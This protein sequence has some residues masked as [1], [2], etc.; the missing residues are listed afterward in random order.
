MRSLRYAKLP[1]AVL[2]TSMLLAACSG[3]SGNNS[4]GGEDYIFTSYIGQP[5]NALIPG[6]TTESEGAEVLSAL[7]TG[8][9]TYAVKD[10][11][12]EYN[13]VAE[14]IESEDLQN[15][16]I[17]LNEGWTFHDGTPV[18]SDS[19]I[20]AWNYTAK[21]ENAF[22]GASF[23]SN[24]QGYEQVAGK[25]DDDGNITEQASADALS[26]LKK[27]DDLTFQV[28]LNAPFAAYPT[29]VGYNAYL[30]LPES[31]F[32]DPAAYEKKP[33]GNGPYKIDGEWSKD[34]GGK[35]VKYA[36][37]KGP[38]K[39]QNAGVQFKIYQ[40]INTGY[41]D[42]QAGNIDV[43][44][45]LPVD[46]VGTAKQEFGERYD[47]TPSPYFGYV[48]FP[49][50]DPRF[51]D[52]RVRQAFSMAIDRQAI[53]DAI[54]PGVATPASS[55]IPPVIPGH[56]DDAC[57]Y[58]TF[59]PEAAKKL[60]AETGFDTSQPIELW[61][62]AGAGHDEYMQAIGNQLKENLGI[63]YQ[64]KGDLQFAQY[65]PK[66]DSKGMTGPFRLAWNMD[67][68]HPQNYLELLFSKSAIP[69]AGSNT[70]FWT[71]DEF[72]AKVAEANKQPNLDEGV[73]I[74][75]AAEDILLEDMPMIPIYNKVDQAVWGNKISNVEIDGFGRIVYTQVKTS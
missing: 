44:K 75:Q 53:I 30:P 43:M 61:F 38:D 46:A 22:R 10:N 4:S 57:K 67:Y 26:G 62:N 41:T 13:G 14:S 23:F 45:D 58:C 19:F 15:W 12:V 5:R 2:A 20:K 37:Y 72:E 24:V 25:R 56:R 63:D 47:Q 68:P 33:I 1:T 3:G 69:P 9:V 74:Y 51:A 31:F 49:T 48:G 64:L 50:Y 27:V 71:N 21:Q 7:F 18:T 54:L 70:S 16:T 42:L 35:V 6:N 28:A 55:V 73:K 59:D 29:T 36:D 40:D 17:K 34:T 32:A 8:L 66:L 65:L 11:K 39:A 60:L 52:K